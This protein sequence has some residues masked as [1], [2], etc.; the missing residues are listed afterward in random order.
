MYK[1]ER[2]GWPGGAGGGPKI[3]HYRPKKGLVSVV[4]KY[5]NKID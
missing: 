5:T 2:R 1:I 3:V 4:H